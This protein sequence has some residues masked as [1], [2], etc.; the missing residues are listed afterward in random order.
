MH[1]IVAG[2][3]RFRLIQGVDHQHQPLAVGQASHSLGQQFAQETGVS[4]GPVG[5]V[6]VRQIEA[7]DDLGAQVFQAAVGAG[8]ALAGA[9]EVHGHV[10]ALGEGRGQRRLPQTSIRHDAKVAAAMA[11][12]KAIHSLKDEFAAHKPPGHTGNIVPEIVAEVLQRRIG[13]DDGGVGVA[14][15]GDGQGLLQQSSQLGRRRRSLQWQQR[16]Y[17]TPGCRTP[18]A[19]LAWCR[20]S[21]FSPSRKSCTTGV[22]SSARFW[23]RSGGK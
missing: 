23:R 6:G 9:E 22:I 18:G 7:N 15:V 17:P 10:V 19:T 16:R 14:E 1:P 3:C 13:V 8:D 5:Q 4:A 11:G 12:E 2:G 21:F 20:S